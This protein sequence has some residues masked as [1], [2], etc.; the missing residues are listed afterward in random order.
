METDILS[1]FL[2]EGG[3]ATLF[4]WMLYS[5]MITNKERKETGGT[6]VVYYGVGNKALAAR[7]S[8]A[9]S[10]ALGIKDRG[11]KKRTDLGF[12]EGTSKPAILIE[13]D[14]GKFSTLAYQSVMWFNNQEASRCRSSRLQT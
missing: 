1:M 14:K 8:K 11:A 6:E 10:E 4:V 5:T 7:V 12:L 3:F 9:I 13:V 2:K